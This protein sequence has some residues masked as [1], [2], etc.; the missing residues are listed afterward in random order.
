MKLLKGKQKNKV[1]WINRQSNLSEPRNLQDLHM[2][3]LL[4]QKL[5]LSTKSEMTVILHP[6][7]MDFKW[8]G[9]IKQQGWSKDSLGFEIFNFGI[10]WGRKILASIFLGSL[11]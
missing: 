5:L 10:F 11:I 6:R 2:K 9:M 7:G 4:T 3:D 8:T 1:K